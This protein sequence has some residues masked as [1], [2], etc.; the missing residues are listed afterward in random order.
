MTDTANRKAPTLIAY[1]VSEGENAVWT[2]IG[3]AWSHEDR[4]GINLQLDVIPV[5]FSGRIVLR[6]PKVK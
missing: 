2:R 4:K 6:E 5:G 3:A 1:G